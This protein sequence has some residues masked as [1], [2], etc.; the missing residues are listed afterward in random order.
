[1]QIYLVSEQEMM[2]DPFSLKLP[3]LEDLTTG[4]DIDKVADVLLFARF[5]I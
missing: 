4:R 3:H 1:M 2:F 5:T